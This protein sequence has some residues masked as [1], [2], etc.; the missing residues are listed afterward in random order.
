MAM[1]RRKL[2]SERCI[3]SRKDACGVRKRMGRDAGYIRESSGRRFWGAE[4]WDTRVVLKGFKQEEACSDLLKS[5]RDP[6]GGM[7][8]PQHG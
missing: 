5:R 4:H 7:E 1:K 2:M 3:R 8:M 6:V